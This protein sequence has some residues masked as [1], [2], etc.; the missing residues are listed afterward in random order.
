MN[1]ETMNY[2]FETIHQ[3]I[4]H[5]WKNCISSDYQDLFLHREDSLK[6]AFYYHL[7]LTLGDDFLRANRLRIYT[8]FHYRNLEHPQE[9]ADLVVVQLDKK[10]NIVEVLATIEFKYKGFGV[11]DHHYHKDVEK[12]IRY[13][14]HHPNDIFKNTHF[15]LAFINETNY[16][17][18]DPEHLSY[19]TTEQRATSAGRITELLSYFEDTA[20]TWYCISH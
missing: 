4:Q 19:A 18:I 16:E 3:A 20:H 1:G 5:V 12:V 15:Y 13:I 11:S 9:R 8:E 10:S 17:P 6:N 7:R 2:L 14:W